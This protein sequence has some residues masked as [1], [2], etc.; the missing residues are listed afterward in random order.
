[1]MVGFLLLPVVPSA[2]M[3]RGGGADIMIVARGSRIRRR[4][5]LTYAVLSMAT[6]SEF[7]AVTPS[8]VVSTAV[9]LHASQFSCCS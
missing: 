5:I 7:K 1:M 9:L 6:S 2:M 4:Y 3:S 8:Y